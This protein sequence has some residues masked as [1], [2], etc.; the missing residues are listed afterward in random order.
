M[1]SGWV[2][3][4]VREWEWESES[5]W[6]RERHEKVLG[7]AYLSH[8]WGPDAV[9]A[10]FSKAVAVVV[11]EL[12]EEKVEEETF[13]LKP[14]KNVFWTSLNN[15][16][17]INSLTQWRHRVVSEWL[18]SSARQ[19]YR[20]VD[21]KLKNRFWS[22]LGDFFSLK[23]NRRQ[24]LW[25]IFQRLFPTLT[26]FSFG[27]KKGETFQ[28]KTQKSKKWFYSSHTFLLIKKY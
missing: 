15:R 21:L 23:I 7:R 28:I 2:G 16:P 8:V 13:F 11:E 4:W 1:R 3:E 5:E 27:V 22:E 10:R 6:E 19:E 25:L 24:H 26:R 9:E 17:T 18:Q 12:Q 14:I 20:K